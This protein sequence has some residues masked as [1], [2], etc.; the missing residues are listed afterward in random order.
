MRFS[1]LL[2]LVLVSASAGAQRR[3]PEERVVSGDGIVAVT[4]NGAPGRIRIDPAAPAIPMFTA[5]FAAG[6]ARLRAGPFAFGYMVGP[7][8]V[9]GLTAVGRIA[10][11]DGARPRKRRIGWTPRTYVQGADG[12][13]GPGG[14]PERVVRFV[15]RPSLP[16]ERTVTLPL[17]DEGGLFGGWGGSYALIDLAGQPLRVRFDPHAPR[18]LA[19]A[20][21]AVRIANA[22]DGI[23]SGDAVPM[24][25]AF[26]ISRPVR[27]MRLGRP[28]T[29]GP[30]TI[31]ELG[32]RTGDF[33]NTATI[34]EAGGDPDEIVVTGDRRRTSRW[35][36]LALGADQLRHCS[37]IVFDRRRREVRLTCAPG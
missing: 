33:G 27:N 37:S 21:A 36:R 34:R 14:V 19:T 11:G 18:T 6:Q 1:P 28:L 2:C 29:V 7:Q 23:V 13:I 4:L 8:Q 25:I 26:G 3:Q 17:E 20:G 31:T 15:L 9:P 10:I 5:P 16:G 35:D 30:L 12:V 24:H 32:I 22:Q